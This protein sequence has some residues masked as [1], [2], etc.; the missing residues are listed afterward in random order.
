VK[1]KNLIL[2]GVLQPEEKFDF[3]M[4][5]PPFFETIDEANQNPSTICTGTVNEMVTE[6]GEFSFVLKIIQDSLIL[7]DKVRLYTSMLG[8]KATLKQLK[9]ELNK[10]KIFN[11]RTTEFFIKVGQQ[12]GLLH[13]I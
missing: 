13:G 2:N 7:K 3:C 10:L 11:I 6:G 4:C 8:K 1:D 9:T 12:G 5:N